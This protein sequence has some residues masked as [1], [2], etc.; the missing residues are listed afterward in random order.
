MRRQSVRLDDAA[1]QIAADPKAKKKKKKGWRSTLGIPKFGAK[2]NAATSSLQSTI[3]KVDLQGRTSEDIFLLMQQ[4]EREQLD[5]W[6][7]I[8][9]PQEEVSSCALLPV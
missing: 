7:K 3:N 4:T 8:Q 9:A 1:A 2:K 5:E 6:D